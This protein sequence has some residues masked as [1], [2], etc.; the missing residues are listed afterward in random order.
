MC[1]PTQVALFE[2][3]IRFCRRWA[4]PNASR[5]TGYRQSVKTT[6]GADTRE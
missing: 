2:A 4:P 6:D 5:R 1:D 3:R